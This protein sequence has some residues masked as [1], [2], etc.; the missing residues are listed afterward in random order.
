MQHRPLADRLS[1]I[2]CPEPPFFLGHYDIITFWYWY[3][4]QAHFQYWGIYWGFCHDSSSVDIYWSMQ[5][6]FSLMYKLFPF[7]DIENT[8]AAYA[9][10]KFHSNI[11]IY[12]P[13]FAR[14]YD[15]TSKI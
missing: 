11:I 7:D 14:P 10:L 8:I 4:Q 12:I 9:P 2:V 1:E 15:K 6:I 5:H 3:A 13:T